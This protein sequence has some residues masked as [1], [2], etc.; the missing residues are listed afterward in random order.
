MTDHSAFNPL[1]C[2]ELPFLQLPQASTSTGS[3][4]EFGSIVATYMPLSVHLWD[5]RDEHLNFFNRCGFVRL[6]IITLLSTCGT[7][8]SGEVEQKCEAQIVLPYLQGQ[9]HYQ[10]NQQHFRFRDSAIYVPASGYRIRLHSSICTAVVISFP[11]ESLLPV[12]RAIAGPRFD[13]F[14]LCPM[15]E[16]PA[17][18]IRED[19]PRRERGHR[20]LV[21]ALC[22]CDQAIALTGSLNPM[23]CLDDL[24]RRLL[25]LLLLPDLLDAVPEPAPADGFAHKQLVDWLLAHLHEP[26]SLSDLERVSRYGRRSL[27]ASFKQRYGCGPMQW[28]RRQRLAKARSL[29]AQ[30]NPHR[31]LHELAQACGYLSTSSFSRDFLSRYGERPSRVLRRFQDQAEPRP[32][33]PR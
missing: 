14:S 15:M 18:L 11:P 16:R 27:Q 29:M 24:I 5:L 7:A 33:P 10:L 28:L 17:V 21:E 19:D 25:L 13:A 9:H 6:G 23:L 20:L 32:L 31:S 2:P 22:F 26:I 12:A 1:A 8:I 3:C 4:E 30:A